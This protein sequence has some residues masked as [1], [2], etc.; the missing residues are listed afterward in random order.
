MDGQGSDDGQDYEQQ[1]IADALAQFARRESTGEEEADDSIHVLH[2]AKALA[3]L[4]Q[5]R[6]EGTVGDA[7]S[8]Q[9]VAG[10]VAQKMRKRHR[11]HRRYIKVA[12]K[13]PT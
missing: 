11:V 6:E 3:T 2:R 4:L 7:G 12:K 9:P 13:Q 8:S 5:P 1:R 10:Q